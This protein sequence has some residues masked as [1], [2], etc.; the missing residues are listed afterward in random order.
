LTGP[1]SSARPLASPELELADDR[2]VRRRVAFD[3]WIGRLLP[4]TFV[5]VLFPI[6]DLVYWIGTEALPTLSWTTLTTDPVG[7][8]G[9]LYAPL[10]G[11]AYL[12]G[13]ATA[14]STALG[15]LAGA[16]TAEF[17]SP[18]VALVGRLLANL[19]TGTP[20][21]VV[22]YFGYFALVLYT[23]STFTLWAGA[24]TLSIFMLPYVYR[25]TD[26][27][28]TSVP[29]TQREAS[30]GVGSTRGQYLRRVAFP[31]AFPQVLSGIFLAMAIGAGE[32]APLL[33]TAGWS[34]TPAQ[35]LSS[36]TSYLSGF[37]WNY[38]DQPS[39]LG[40]LVVLSFQAAFLLIVGVLLLNVAVQVVS[41]RYRRRL[42]GFF[43]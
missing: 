26:A 28:F 8:G 9:G 7:F 34:I 22:G 38:F 24:V 33:F 1:F 37:I 12:L 2:H 19:L 21:I 42:R 17:A 20:A 4:L 39:N 10:T 41:E 25:V 31:I 5:A 35:S 36:P 30:L 16:Y 29:P 23:H 27:A 13:I 15:V 14:I 3:R 6:G 40:H 43:A 18:R 32:T 11:T